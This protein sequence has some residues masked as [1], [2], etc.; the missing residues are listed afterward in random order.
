[1]PAQRNHTNTLGRG[2]WRSSAGAALTAAAVFAGA[3]AADEPVTYTLILDGQGSAKLTVDAKAGV[4]ISYNESGHVTTVQFHSPVLLPAIARNPA[5]P[6]ATNPPPNR[7]T[8]LAPLAASCPVLAG[9]IVAFKHLRRRKGVP[10]VTHPACSH[11]LTDDHEVFVSYAREDMPLI[12]AYL[13]G[14]RAAGVRLWIDDDGIRCGEPIVGKISAAIDRARVGLIF[15]SQRYK[16]RPWSQAEEQAMVMKLMSVTT[17]AGARPFDVHVIRL[18][19]AAIDPLLSARLWSRLSDGPGKVAAWI[20]SLREG[21]DQNASRTPTERH[22][23]EPCPPIDDA[24]FG[25]LGGV[26]IE[27]FAGNVRAA[28]DLNRQTVVYELHP[29]G[30]IKCSLRPSVVASV[31]FSIGDLLE[32]C[33]ALTIH[34]NEWQRELDTGGLGAFTPAFKIRIADTLKRLDERRRELLALLRGVIVRVDRCA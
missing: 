12:E 6:V 30:K 16:E 28:L 1:M 13:A 32:S 5:P 18:D 10:A 3:A 17:G 21:R 34:V 22:S 23:D 24:F 29:I 20:H 26:W 4:S 15:H 8:W 31:I 11:P 19:D 33:R 7:W 27:D 14:L 25:A 9:S 2:A